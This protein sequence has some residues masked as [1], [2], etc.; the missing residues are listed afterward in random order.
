[1]VGPKE[2]RE[3]PVE[4]LFFEL[5]GVHEL[6]ALGMIFPGQDRKPHLHLHGSAGREGRSHTGCL[7]PGVETWQVGEVVLLEITGSNAR[8]VRDKKTGF[9]LLTVR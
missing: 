4:P 5:F 2:E 3:R 7:R 8:R 6:L 1:M 9:D